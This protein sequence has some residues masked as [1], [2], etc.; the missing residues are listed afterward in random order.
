[1]TKKKSFDR[2]INA[3]PRT[4]RERYGDEMAALL[5]DHATNGRLPLRHKLSVVSGGLAERWHTDAGPVATALQRSGAVQVLCAWT[6]FA[7]GGINFAKFSEHWQSTVNPAHR[8]VASASYVVVQGGALLATVL[9]VVGAMIVVPSFLRYV[10]REG[11]REL[12]ARIRIPAALSVASGLSLL[13]IVLWAHTLSV[14]QR[15]GGD[16]V[17]SL[18]V[19]VFSLLAV[20]C[21]TSWTVVVARFV[22]QLDLSAAVVRGEAVLAALLTGLM[23]VMAAAVVVWWAAM[24][25]H[26]P[27]FFPS[28]EGSYASS[29]SAIAPAMILTI[30]VM[31][32]A[33]VLALGGV[34]RTVTARRA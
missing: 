32:S 8:N 18:A 30:V 21:L 10:R 20:V 14:A 33:L 15:N 28:G 3:Y 2:W 11:W 12:L 16:G 7:I 22:F 1:M 13:G 34:F 6:A 24:A 25:T 31:G 9:I 4:W 5:E 26:A 29:G 19:S 17:Y 27:G 23:A